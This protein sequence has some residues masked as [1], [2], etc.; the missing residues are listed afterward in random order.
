MR[1]RRAAARPSWSPTSD[2]TA[3]MTPNTAAE[4]HGESPRIPRLP[5]GEQVVQAQRQRDA[6]QRP[7]MVQFVRLGM[8]QGGDEEVE[9]VPAEG[10]G[11]HYVGNDP[12]RVP[13]PLP[14]QQP[15]QGHDR[16]PEPEDQRHLHRA[17]Q[18]ERDGAERDRNPEIV[19]T[20]HKTEDEHL[21]DHGGTTTR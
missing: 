19:E 7:R 13:D 4:N 11:A 14:D 21:P 3:V 6:E 16:V 18:T 5:P 2:S 9:T 20:E 10:G 17:L 1:M 15:Q 12:E 8:A